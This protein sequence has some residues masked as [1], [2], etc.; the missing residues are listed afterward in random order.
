MSFHHHYLARRVTAKSP[1]RDPHSV[2]SAIQPN[3]N[4][5]SWTRLLV[6]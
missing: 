4:P 6:T 3:L 5:S 1:T 2:T